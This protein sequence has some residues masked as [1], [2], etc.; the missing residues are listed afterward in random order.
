M[1]N[2]KII[3]IFVVLGGSILL[4]DLYITVK[5]LEYEKLRMIQ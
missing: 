4:I 2:M 1:E 5:K 3:N